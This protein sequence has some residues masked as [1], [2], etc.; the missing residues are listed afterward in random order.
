[1]ILQ[2]N[3]SQSKKMNI[4]NVTVAFCSAIMQQEY[5]ARLSIERNFKIYAI[6]LTIG[7]YI[8]NIAAY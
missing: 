2:R 5:R 3:Y 8:Y 4:F 6:Y 1:M 7:Q